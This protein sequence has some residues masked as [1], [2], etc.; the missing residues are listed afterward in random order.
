MLL[1]LV[2]GCLFAITILRFS[3]YSSAIL[4]FG[5]SQAYISVASAIGHWNFAGLQIKQFWGYPYAMALVSVV[6]RVS[7]QTALLAVSCTSSLLSV[8]FAYRLWG[9]WIAGFFAVL[10]FDWMQRSFLGGSEPL[11]VALIFGAFLAMREEQ[12]LLAAFLASLSTVV[13]PLSIFC[14]IGICVVLVHK[15]E[16]RKLTLAILIAACVATLY[17]WP[18]ARHFGDP[19]ATVHSYQDPSVPLFGIPFYAIVKGTI[20]YPAPWTNLALSFLWL[21]L[22]LS[23]LAAAFFNPRFRDYVRRNPTEIL[24]AAPYLL[25]VFCYNYPVFARTNFARFAIPVLPFIFLALSRWIP[26]DRRVLWLLGAATSVLAAASALG[27]RN[28]IHMLRG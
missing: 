14:L 3:D 20:L 18:L 8:A 28:V 2:S 22:V 7:D 11:A 15:R 26:K 1:A 25:L 9:G 19:L 13:R 4:D 24:F 16:V 17:L 10:N 12:H 23:G 21:L 27:I 5:D 6:T